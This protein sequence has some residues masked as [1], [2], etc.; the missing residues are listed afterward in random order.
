MNGQRITR[1]ALVAGLL[2]QLAP[3]TKVLASST[4]IYRGLWLQLG[5]HGSTRGG[6]IPIRIVV[7]QDGRPV[8]GATVTLKSSSETLTG[9]TNDQGVVPFTLKAGSYKATASADVGVAAKSLLVS[10][11]RKSR[12][13]SLTIA[14][15]RP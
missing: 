8:S 1:L 11:K 9:T 3:T 15:P 4:P 7:K 13:F 10:A 2:L 14:S 6:G 5:G 12:I